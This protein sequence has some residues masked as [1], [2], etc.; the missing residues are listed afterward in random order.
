MSTLKIFVAVAFFAA[1]GA[2]LATAKPL[3]DQFR[4]FGLPRVAM[5][6][7]GALEIAGAIGLF[8]EGVAPWAALGLT[9]LMVGAVAN[10]LKAKHAFGKC[11]PSAVLA[12]LTAVLVLMLWE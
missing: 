11:A 3:L 12:V 2:K 9:A 1:G 8:V 10:H 6:V 5:Y 4:E 7:V